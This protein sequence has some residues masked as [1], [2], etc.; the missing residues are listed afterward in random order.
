MKVDAGRCDGR[1]ECV[2]VR[3]VEAVIMVDGVTEL[4]AGKRIAR[5]RLAG[6]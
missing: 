3:A 1:L 2:G 5:F 6:A 4:D